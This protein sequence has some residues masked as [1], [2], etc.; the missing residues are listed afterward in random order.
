MLSLSIAKQ[1]KRDNKMENL[2]TLTTWEY[3]T[4]SP[5]MWQ[6][7]HYIFCRHMAERGAFYKVQI[8]NQ[9]NGSIEEHKTV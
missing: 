8:V 4:S 9:G 2:F 1:L 6:D 3:E 7:Q 5:E